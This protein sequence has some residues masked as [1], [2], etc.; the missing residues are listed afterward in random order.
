VDNL[1]TWNVVQAGVGI[2]V[3]FSLGG[4]YGLDIFATG[5]P[6]AQKIT[7]GSGMPQDVIEETVLV[8]SSSLSYDAVSDTYTYVWKT[9][10]TWATTCRQL[11]I[12]LNDGTE[13]RANFKFIR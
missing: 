8:G 4:D 2:P 9:N 12:W 1:P 11:I 13:H 10:K 7:C 3:R 6:M 5:Y